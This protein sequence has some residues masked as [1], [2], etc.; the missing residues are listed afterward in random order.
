MSTSQKT[1]SLK[2]SSSRPS[3]E[4][5]QTTGGF[6]TPKRVSES[7]RDF[8]GAHAKAMVEER[9]KMAAWATA[10]EQVN[11]TR[12]EAKRWE[13]QN[14]YLEAIRAAFREELAKK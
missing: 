7:D 8:L 5:A 9:R 14:G 12:P 2:T 1:P 10:K 11:R 3:S 6:W 13:D 4:S